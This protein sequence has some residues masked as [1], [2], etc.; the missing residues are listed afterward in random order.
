[1]VSMV[2]MVSMKTA[3]VQ[4]GHEA[5]MAAGYSQSLTAYAAGNQAFIHK[6]N[7]FLFDTGEIAIIIMNM[8]FSV[9][10]VT[11]CHMKGHLP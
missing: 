4:P 11:I 3:S 6:K 10:V 2:S 5:A 7:G 9:T 8:T 1:M